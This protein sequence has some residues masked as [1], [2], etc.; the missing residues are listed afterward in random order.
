MMLDCDCCTLS[1][2]K[3]GTL[4]VKYTKHC[5]G[6]EVSIEQTQKMCKL[7]RCLLGRSAYASLEQGEMV[8]GA[9]A[10]LGTGPWC[11]GCD[12]WDVGDAVR[13]VRK[14]PPEAQPPEPEVQ[15]STEPQPE[16]RQKATKEEKVEAAAE[17]L[18]L[19]LGLDD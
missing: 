14:D 19:R 6:L 12:L 18:G 1:V 17:R 5:R 4:L 13:I 11:W 8:P 16:S 15:P 7:P 9:G 2:F 10:A 3:N